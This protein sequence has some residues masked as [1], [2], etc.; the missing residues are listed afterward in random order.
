MS[1]QDQI[2]SLDGPIATVT[3]VV[4]R[5]A[6]KAD[7]VRQSLRACLASA[8]GADK[9]ARDL[10]GQLAALDADKDFEEQHLAALK[11]RRARIA[12]EQ[13]AEEAAKA[14]QAKVD[15]F[16]AVVTKRTQAAAKAQVA[17]DQL[18]QAAN[19]LTAAN[20]ELRLAL[21]TVGLQQSAVGPDEVRI[22]LETSLAKIVPG[23]VAGGGAASLDSQ[24]R[25][26]TNVADRIRRSGDDLIAMLEV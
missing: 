25:P 26:L 8:D 2:A 1:F 13:A 5:I 16:T 6:A 4:E 24:G 19:E 9:K 14:R 12:A 11:E 18:G 17:I 7:A 20:T 10:H 23:I 21:S 3:G 15:A 22:G